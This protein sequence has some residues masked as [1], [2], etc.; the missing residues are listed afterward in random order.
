VVR[1][2]VTKMEELKTKGLSYAQQCAE[3]EV[4]YSSLMR[5]R[6][7]IKDG[8][9]PVMAPGPKKVARP[10]YKR[11]ADQVACLRHGRHRSRGVKV[12]LKEWHECISRRELAWMVEEARLLTN[13]QQEA[14]YSRITWQT[15]GLVWA[16]DDCFYR[17]LATR[18]AIHLH[19][20]QDMAS[21]YKFEPWVTGPLA[22]GDEVA[23]NLS[24]L[25]TRHG[26]P[27]FMK[28]DNGS[29]LN[30]EAV[31]QVLEEWFVIPL[32]GPPYYPRYNGSIERC[33]REMK[34]WLTKNEPESLKEA[35]VQAALAV[36]DLNHR[37]RPCLKGHTACDRLHGEARMTRLNRRKRKEVYDWTERTALTIMAAGRREC[38]ASAA[39]RLAVETWLRKNGHIT[40]TNRS[41]VLPTLNDEHSHN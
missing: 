2:L 40:V 41:K 15:P 29:N 21:R 22:S 6:G 25:F 38:S 34:E 9:E 30:S 35:Q 5:W 10:D 32:N 19:N 18:E 12:L 28:R 31:N 36:H 39:W 27:L 24:N 17:L 1:T 3:S 4:A 23:E 37:K 7:R 26:A 8:L 16:M 20:V 33:Q 11:L 14:E 13:R